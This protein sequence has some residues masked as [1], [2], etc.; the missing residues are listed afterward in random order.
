MT[1]GTEYAIYPSV[2]V[3]CQSHIID[4]GGR[5]EVFGHCN[6]FIPKAEVVDAIWALGH[7]EEA[8]AVGAL[9]AAHE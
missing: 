4:I 8:F 9:H 6:G 7:R 1:L 2:L 5:N 3:L